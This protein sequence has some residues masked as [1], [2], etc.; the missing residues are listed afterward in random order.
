MDRFDGFKA[1]EIE[2]CRIPEPF[3]TDLLPIIDDLDELKLTLYA[4]WAL[5][6]QESNIRYLNLSEL[7]A[8][9]TLLQILD[10]Q[11][12][13]EILTSAIHKAVS[14]GI[15]LELDL[16][17]DLQETLY[18]FNTAKSRAV[19]QAFH[20]GSWFPKE[21]DHLPMDVHQNPHK[22]I[23]Q[24]YEENIGPLTPML[25][26][27][28]KAAEDEYS[29]EWIK[30]AI[31]IALQNNVRT[32]R[33]IEAILRSWKKEGKD[34]VTRRDSEQDGRRY[35]EGEFADYIQH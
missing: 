18:F 10:A 14:R 23:Y 12:D 9:S 26:E 28:L 4:I 6:K 25:A 34:A 7:R 13:L 32:W 24:L 35:L 29:N 20:N 2:W 11:S 5:E 15:L 16:S 22:N 8:D 33:Y 27:D 1:G 17:E 30:D 3:Y 21:T 31:H 19:I